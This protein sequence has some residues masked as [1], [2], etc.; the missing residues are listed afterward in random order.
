MPRNEASGDLLQLRKWV[1]PAIPETPALKKSG[2]AC[3]MESR[4]RDYGPPE[5]REHESVR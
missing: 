4:A 1:D 3:P 2:F 5:G